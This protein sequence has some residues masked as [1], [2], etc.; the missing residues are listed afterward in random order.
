MTIRLLLVDDHEVVLEGICNLLADLED[1]EVVGCASDG[2]AAV[3]MAEE[4]GPDVVVMDVGLPELNGMEATRRI[5]SRLPG[6]KVIALSMR[7]NTRFVTEMLGAGV[8]TY[9]HKSCN[10]EELIQ[11]IRSVADHE[12]PVEH[13]EVE[14]EEEAGTPAREASENPSLS[15]REVEV[16]T[17]LAEGMST[18]E[19]ASRFDVSISTVETH[20]RRI[21]NKL[22]IHSV[23]ELTKYAVLQ[24]LTPLER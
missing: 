24:G 15:R 8:T 5:T 9:L 23:A 12:E 4:L 20:R 17:C 22:D 14:D 18:R 16:L 11:A 13:P 21:M 19:I 3:R 1:I 2:R 6:I 10:I 7:I